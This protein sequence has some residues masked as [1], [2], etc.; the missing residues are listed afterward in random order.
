[1]D[2]EDANGTSRDEGAE[3]GAF[4]E[5]GDERQGGSA[6]DEAART[7]IEGGY[8]RSRAEL[9]R[10]LPRSAG[11]GDER[12]AVLLAVFG[13]GGEGLRE[14][15][16]IDERQRERQH[17]YVKKRRLRGRTYGGA[18]GG[19]ATDGVLTTPLPSRY[20]TNEEFVELYSA[21]AFANRCGIVLNCHVTI[22]WR[23]LGYED[24]GEVAKA[25]AGFTKRFREW[26]REQR[27]P[28]VWVYSHENSPAAGLHTH[29][30]L[31]V[32]RNYAD[33][34]REYVVK[35]LCRQ[36]RVK[37]LTEIAAPVVVKMRLPRTNNLERR[38]ETC[39]WAQ[40]LWLQYICKGIRPRSNMIGVRRPKKAVE[41]IYVDD[42][43]MFAPQDPGPVFCANRVG[44]SENV[45]PEQ[46][47]LGYIQEG[48]L[49]RAPNFRS[50]LEMNE[51]DVRRLYSDCY[52][53]DFVAQARA[54]Y[55][56]RGIDVDELFEA[57]ASEAALKPRKRAVASRVKAPGGRGR[58]RKRV[59]VPRRPKGCAETPAE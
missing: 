46:R 31:Y 56:L 10:A 45:G 16:T 52:H 25:F 48:I 11:P 18:A 17:V 9:C 29:V 27:F 2:F 7:L 36:S 1:M 3:N 53:R 8:S 51:F 23:A 59:L 14:G 38:W 4:D 39:I 24:H 54:L 22:L 37:P 33:I 41:H 21:V 43:I 34:F 57:Q 6:V 55:R 40:W 30:L 15:R 26:C 49:C 32:N 20:I 58:P 5:A 47:R 44:S 13:P 28:A 12:A 35:S 50:R 42:L 19:L